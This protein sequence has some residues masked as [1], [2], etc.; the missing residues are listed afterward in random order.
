[1]LI[2]TWG[3]EVSA[4]PAACILKVF[5]RRGGCWGIRCNVQGKS[6]IPRGKDSMDTDTAM[7]TSNLAEILLFV[8]LYFFGG[9]R[10]D[11]MKLAQDRDGWR[12]LVGTVRN[13]R[14]P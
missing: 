11:W 5:G 3:P 7:I 4:K 9:G 6:H 8:V 2:S 14:V 10:G 13:F 1:M 12:A